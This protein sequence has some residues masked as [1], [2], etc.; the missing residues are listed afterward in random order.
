V[1]CG[2]LQCRFVVLRQQR[3]WCEKMNVA[4]D[5]W[6]TGGVALLLRLLQVSRVAT[7]VTEHIN[8][9]GARSAT[10]VKQW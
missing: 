8:D 4:A 5:Q 10:I 9:G 3:C 6:W 7:N 1:R 2:H